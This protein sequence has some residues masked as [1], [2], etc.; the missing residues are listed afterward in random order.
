M[1]LT[2]RGGIIAGLVAPFVLLPVVARLAIGPIGDAMASA[3]GKVAPAPSSFVVASSEEDEDQTFDERPLPAERRSGGEVAGGE[4]R[5]VARW[6][7]PVSSSA[8]GGDAGTAK[9]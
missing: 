4:P 2:R 3:F 1:K 5:R 8:R 9:S 7:A 6:A